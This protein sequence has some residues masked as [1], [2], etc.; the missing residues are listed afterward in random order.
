[1]RRLINIGANAAENRAYL[2]LRLDVLEERGRVGTVATVAIISRAPGLRCIGNDHA[3]RTIDFCK[4]SS[5]AGAAGGPDRAF[6][7]LGERVVA[8][9][10]QHEDAEVLGW[11][12]VSDDVV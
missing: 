12:H 9:R 3:F 11:L 2:F 1:M 10:I 8:A 4:T 5:N 7:L 6:Q